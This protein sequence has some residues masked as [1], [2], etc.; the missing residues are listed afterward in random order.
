MMAGIASPNLRTALTPAPARRYGDAWPDFGVLMALQFGNC[1]LSFYEANKAGNAVAA[2]KKSLKPSA[3]AKRDGKWAHLEAA[4]LV[5]G[6]LVKLDAGSF[7]PADVE[8]LG[9]GV[10][11]VDQASLTGESLPV[12]MRGPGA[13]CSVCTTGSP[14][15]R[16]HQ[17]ARADSTG[18]NPRGS[19]A[20]DGLKRGA[21]RGGGGCDGHRRLNL[22]G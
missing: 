14:M 9:E 10:V 4:L 12:T 17:R 15:P 7:V 6:D 21:R 16:Q 19:A 8:I 3:L 1:T 11:S 18:R 13:S 5:P 20:K 22:S 2:L